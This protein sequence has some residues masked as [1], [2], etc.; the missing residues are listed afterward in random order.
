MVQVMWMAVAALVTFTAGYLGYSRYLARFVELDEQSETPAHKYNDGQEY[1]P[2]K[3]PV[4][5]GHHYS[6][7]AGGAPIAGPITAAAAFGWLPAVIWVAIGN[8]L[9][10]A[11]HDF[12][13]LSSSVRHEG[14]SIGYIIGEYVGESGKNMLL[15]FAYLTIILVIAAFAYLIGLVFDAF[16]WT[17]TASIVYIALAVVF[18]VYLYQLDL[19]FLPGAVAFVAMVFGGVW[20]G[21]QYPMALFARPDLPAD[22]IILFG[23][24]GGWL[25]LASA[26]N[27]NMAGWVLVTVLY[28]F[29]ASVL[30]VWVLLQPRDFLTS[31]LLYTGVGGMIL[32]AIVGTLAGFTGVTVSVPSAGIDGVQVSS[33]TTQIP[34][35]TGFVHSD[36]GPLF[37]FL[38]VT[39]ACGTISGF[40]SLVSSGTTAKQL[41]KETD[42]R[43]IGYGGMLG[44]G[45]LAI[46]AIIAVSIIAGGTD[47][48]SSALVTFPAGGGALLSVFGLGITAAATFIG[49]VFVSFLLTSTDTAMRLGRYMMEEIVGTPESST[50]ETMT[51]RYVNAG[52][53]S[54]AGYL[55]VASGTWSNIWP[56][57]GG[58]NQSLAALALLVATIWLANWDDNKQL[59]STGVPLVFMLGVTVI[60]LLWI[61]ILRNP[62]DLLAGNYD[63]TFAAVSLVLQSV[64]ALVLV[65]LIV[66]LVRLGV[67]NIRE[68]RQ[69][70]DR[71]A[72][73]G[74]PSDD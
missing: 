35:F 23:D 49:L 8:P 20:V 61:G 10:G 11:V 43:L 30:P 6:S 47:S 33:L 51:N 26:A 25:P 74:G 14:R 50:Q 53:L 54:L 71:D 41:N 56:L 36:L 18:G 69:G 58:A 24:G 15:W 13:S 68:A 9:F 2:S 67:G 52:V 16:P 22:T 70:L 57:F 34:A 40:H 19:P 45:L 1:V 48:L 4:L 62:Q 32:A 64:I 44:E 59:V 72:V 73:T 28:A 60:A 37:P 66:Q 29:A 7:I 38:F 63:G 5:L 27:P 65:G 31:S 39:I 21:L 42:A 12:M 55:L 17:A 46:T 3:K